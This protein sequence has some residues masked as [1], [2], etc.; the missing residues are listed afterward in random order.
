MPVSRH[1]AIA[2]GVETLA[3]IV[4]ECGCDRAVHDTG[5]EDDGIADTREK[6]YSAVD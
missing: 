3:E 4:G 2:E 5:I 6:A 1:H